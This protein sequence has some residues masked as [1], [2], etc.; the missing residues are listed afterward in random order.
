MKRS[1]PL[2]FNFPDAS[3]HI[4]SLVIAERFTRGT[5]EFN[6]SLDPDGSLAAG[7]GL[8]G[9]TRIRAGHM[10]PLA[11]AYAVSGDR[12]PCHLRIVIFAGALRRPPVAAVIIPEDS[13][14]RHPLIA[15]FCDGA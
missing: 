2:N 9:Q 11:S 15:G 10:K 13:P 6:T 14:A 7:N 4:T 1:L 5:P 8:D 3:L 12:Q